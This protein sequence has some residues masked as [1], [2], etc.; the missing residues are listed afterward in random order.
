MVLEVT[1]ILFTQWM[2]YN[3]KSEADS[4]NDSESR[5]GSLLVIFLGQPLP[6]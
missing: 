2:V 3:D 1:G 6:F 5:S 4:S